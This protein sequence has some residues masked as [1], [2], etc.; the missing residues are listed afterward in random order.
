MSIHAH[1]RRAWDERVREGECFTRPARDEDFA[2]PLKT[3]DGIGWLGGD[4]RL[5]VLTAGFYS[6]QLA[7]KVDS[8]AWS[9]IVSATTAT[10]TYRYQAVGHR[11]S[12]R[13]RARDRAGN[14]GAWSV[15]IS[16]SI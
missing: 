13:V 12:Y 8:G 1:N 4:I 14:Y 10:S 15:P 11:Y 6:Y 7:R 2:D 3:V 16:F 5:Q 9:V